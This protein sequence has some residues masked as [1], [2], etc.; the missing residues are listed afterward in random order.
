[1]IIAYQAKHP[2]IPFF[3]VAS[4]S[5]GADTEQNESGKKWQDFHVI[6]CSLFLVLIPVKITPPPCQVLGF[7]MEN[8]DTELCAA[9]ALLTQE[10]KDAVL[11]MVIAWATAPTQPQP[12]AKPKNFNLGAAI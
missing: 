4:K 6:F 1:M 2:A 10:E 12:A 7:D 8:F 5:D 9:C 3:G 11:S